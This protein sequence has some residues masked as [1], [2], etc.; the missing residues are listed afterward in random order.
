MEG[1]LHLDTQRW[2]IGQTC[3]PVMAFQRSEP[4]WGDPGPLVD[5]GMGTKGRNQVLRISIW[6]IRF[7]CQLSS[8]KSVHSREWPLEEAACSGCFLRQTAPK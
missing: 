3:L 7:G 5:P 2:E 1:I 4:K 6:G 8:K